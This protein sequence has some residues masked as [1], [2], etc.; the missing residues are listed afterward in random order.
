MDKET[1]KQLKEEMDHEEF[2]ELMALILDKF[3]PF[4]SQ[5]SSF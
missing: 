4:F 3:H 2:Y 5:T 1:I